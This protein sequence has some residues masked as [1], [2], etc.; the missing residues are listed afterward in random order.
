MKMRSLK[1]GG[2]HNSGKPFCDFF[3]LAKLPTFA[4][5]TQLRIL[6]AEQDDNSVI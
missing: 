5:R 6:S 1:R 3:E 4:F 2:N